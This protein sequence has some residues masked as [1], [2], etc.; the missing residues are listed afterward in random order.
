MRHIMI[1]N[2]KGGCG[3]S[4]LATNVA[5]WYAN[6]GAAVA[7]GPTRHRRPRGL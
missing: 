5:S 2:A 7:R 6:E 1:L 4:T 3:K